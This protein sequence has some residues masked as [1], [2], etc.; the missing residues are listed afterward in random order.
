[1]H[2][3]SSIYWSGKWWI[4]CDEQE[5]QGVCSNEAHILVGGLFVRIILAAVI[6]RTKNIMAHTQ[7]VVS[8]SHNGT[9]Q[10]FLVDEQV[11]YIKWFGDQG[12]FHF[13]S[14][15]APR[16]LLSLSI[17]MKGKEYMEGAHGLL[18]NLVLE[19]TLVKSAHILE[20]AR[21]LSHGHI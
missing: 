21:S 20:W 16:T 3:L 18:K 1:M 2:A 17:Q 7:Q 8:C 12:S 19:M 4:Y 5:R 14:L 11:L 13:V 10:V 9:M 15:L 6:N